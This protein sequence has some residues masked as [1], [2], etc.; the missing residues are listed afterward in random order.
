MLTLEQIDAADVDWETLDSFPDRQVCQTRAWLSFVMA[1]RGAEAVVAAVRDGRS[2]DLA[3]DALRQA[4]RVVEFDLYGGGSYKSK[5]GATE[6]VIPWA[7]RSR[8]ALVAGRRP[9]SRARHAMTS[10]LASP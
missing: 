2:T 6:T 1:S 5:Y 7:R 4:A 3:R 10:P 8:S 9:R